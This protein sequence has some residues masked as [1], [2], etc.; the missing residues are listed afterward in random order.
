MNQPA[1]F[2]ENCGAPLTPDSRFCE[3]CGSPIKVQHEETVIAGKGLPPQQPG[4]QPTPQPLEVQQPYRQALSAAPKSNKK[5]LIGAITIVLILGAALAGYKFLSHKTGAYP[6]KDAVTSRGNGESSTE[7]TILNTMNTGGVGN[8]PVRPTELNISSPYQITYIMTYHWNHGSGAP[9]GTI[10]LRAAD[11]AMYGPWGVHTEGG[12]GGRVPNAIWIAN[13]NVVIPAGSYT[14]IDSD[15]A[16][17]AQ[18]GQS[19]G[20]GMVEIKGRVQ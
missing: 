13:P 18:N 11:G 1:G 6:E 16:T 19:G 7:E 4:I 10:G 9:G 15:T 17:W 3:K 5:Y 8:D 14:V 2:C 12:N 20:R